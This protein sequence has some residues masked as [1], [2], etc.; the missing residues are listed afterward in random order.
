MN[1]VLEILAQREGGFRL[2]VEEITERLEAAQQRNGPRAGRPGQRQANIAVLPI[3]GVLTPRASLLSSSSGGSSAESIRD[4][5]RAAMDDP[6]VDGVVF[7]VDSPGGVVD[8][9]PELAAELFAARGQKPITAVANTQMASGALWLGAMADKIFA[10]PSAQVGSIGVI[11]VHKDR[12]EKY[13]KEGIKTTIIRTSKFKGEGSDAEPL[14][15]ETK[16]AMLDEAMHYDDLFSADMARGR[17]VSVEH[18]RASYGQGRMF[19]A[20]KAVKAGLIDGI[21]TLEQAIAHTAKMAMDG[22]APTAS[23]AALAN[24]GHD[25]VDLAAQTGSL[26][27]GLPFAE[28]LSLVAAEAEAVAGLARDRA[29]M[30]AEEGRSLSSGTLEHLGRVHA[31]LGV[32]VSEPAEEPVAAAQVASV[33][34]LNLMLRTYEESNR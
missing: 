4:D 6:K 20:P 28:R 8:G 34:V 26:E 13:A 22:P 19:V 14:S 11:G 12:S 7:D 1:V 15:D 29:A 27:S 30:R 5:F 17:G 23:R 3:Y 9:L 33:D 24:G 16:A 25:V 2:S 32:L 10:S 21:M 31:A 18:V